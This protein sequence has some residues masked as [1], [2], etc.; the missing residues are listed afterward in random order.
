ML[1]LSLH[2]AR[3]RGITMYKAKNIMHCFANHHITEVLSAKSSQPVCMISGTVPRFAVPDD[4]AR[5]PQGRW[6]P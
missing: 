4:L 6:N 3:E 2:E 5:L 1:E